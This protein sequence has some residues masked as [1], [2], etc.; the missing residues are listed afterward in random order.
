MEN[1]L[2]VKHVM[3]EAH[4]EANLEEYFFQ[5]GKPIRFLTRENYAQITYA[6]EETT[7]KVLNAEPHE[8]SI[9]F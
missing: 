5:F 6:D 9:H 3:S 1:S 7:Q 8:A 4:N 2:L